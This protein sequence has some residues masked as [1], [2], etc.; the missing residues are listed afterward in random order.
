MPPEQLHEPWRSFLHDI[1][2]QLAG[3]TEI[4]CFGGFVVAEYYG[5]ARP[6]ADVDIIRVRGAS[7][8]ADVQ[9]IG[10]KGSPLAKK[11]RVYL[12]IVTVADV[13]ERYE[14]RLLD[15]YAG[16]FR[17]LRVRVFERHDLALAK[18]GRNQDYDREDVRRLAQGPGLDVAI[19]EQRYRDELR[20]QLGN[21]DRE[22]LTLELWIEML[23]ELRGGMKRTSVES[24]AIT[25]VGYD[26]SRQ[27]LELEYIDGDVY[28]YF[29]VPA[30]LH[31]AL[32]DAPSIGQFVNAEIKG[33]FRYEKI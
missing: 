21:P 1:D 31:R 14:E 28:R 25:S 32:L 27:V 16:E 18:L 24:S 17:N 15:V 30:T 33:A 10:G 5:L 2:A 19:L 8:V 29:D 7:D 26:E 3:P 20:W 12:D 9:R 13:P 4:H 6:T 11:H 23:T 22:D